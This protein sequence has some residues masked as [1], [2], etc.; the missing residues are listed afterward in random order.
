MLEFIYFKEHLELKGGKYFKR[1]PKY[2]LGEGKI[3][4]T[5][6]CS[7]ESIIYPQG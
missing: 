5:S 3:I 7:Y 2:L 6:K 1:R 4:G